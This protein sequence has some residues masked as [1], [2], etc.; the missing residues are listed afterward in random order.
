MWSEIF[1]DA[2]KAAST[3]TTSDALAESHSL[4]LIGGV[5]TPAECAHLCEFSRDLSAQHT[6]RTHDADGQTVQPGRFRGHVEECLDDKSKTLC[7]LIL[8]RAVAQI[9]AL[10]PG[11]LPRFFKDLDLR[12]TVLRHPGLVFSKGEPAINIYTQGGRFDSHTDKQSLTILVP[13]SHARDAASSGPIELAALPV[14]APRDGE[15]YFEGGGTSFYSRRTTSNAAE[16][17]RHCLPNEAVGDT[18]PPK[19]VVRPPPGTAIVFGG[20]MRHAGVPVLEGTRVVLVASFS[21]K[22]RTAATSGDGGTSSG[23]VEHPFLPQVY[24]PQAQAKAAL[25]GRSS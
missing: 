3:G 19:V 21:A 16:L 22:V 1:V 7:D 10:L 11:L 8:C 23:W 12:E 15:L 14:P 25:A 18:A 20:A 13:L 9:N 2:A 5:A 6:E 4:A 24:V 17:R